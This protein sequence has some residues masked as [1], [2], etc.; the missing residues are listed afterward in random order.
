MDWKASVATLDNEVR[1]FGTLVETGRVSDV[2][3][4]RKGTYVAK[5]ARSSLLASMVMV[6]VVA[7]VMWW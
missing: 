3:Q 1:V 6:S 4:R 5:A 2:R 7:V